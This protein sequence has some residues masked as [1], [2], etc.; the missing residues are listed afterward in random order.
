MPK[1]VVSQGQPFEVEFGDERFDARAKLLLSVEADPSDPSGQ[2]PR[3]VIGGVGVT[4][5][6][7]GTLQN[8]GAPVG[9]GGGAEGDAE[10]D[11]LTILAPD[12]A[13]G[14]SPPPLQVGTD[15]TNLAQEVRVIFVPESYT[16]AGAGDGKTLTA[17]D[18]GALADFINLEVSAGD[19]V[20][21]TD[22]GVDNG[23]YV[24]T[25]PGDE[26]TPWVLTR[27]A[28]FDD[29]NDGGRTGNQLD[30][31]GLAFVV[32]RASGSAGAGTGQ[33]NNTAWLIRPVAP[34]EP[35]S[36]NSEPDVD[37]FEIT[38]FEGPRRGTT[39]LAGG[40]GAIY[41]P[42]LVNG[43]F[44]ML[45]RRTQATTPTDSGQL[46]RAANPSSGRLAI[47]SNDAQD[48]GQ[49]DWLIVSAYLGT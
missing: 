26:N 21:A 34:F 14:V 27:A 31:G 23:I 49:V 2:T 11:S 16:P 13:T 40:A 35:G 12:S 24:V 6:V 33:S 18:D 7:L 43:T 8:D 42:V 20:Y 37:T 15:Y 1:I 4:T 47:A 39:T 44:V 41:S 3:L 29:S 9:G 17:D 25:D 36:G 30:S 19:R 48:D 46:S 32:N 22:V 28:D 38:R 10:L 5:N 45:S